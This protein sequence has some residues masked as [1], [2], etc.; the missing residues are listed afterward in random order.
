MTALPHAATDF[1]LRHLADVRK[2]LHPA[3]AAAATITATMTTTSI[4]T[5]TAA[6]TATA[7][8]TAAAAATAD[9]DASAFAGELAS[10]C[11]E[12]EAA[13]GFLDGVLKGELGVADKAP[14]YRVALLC[15]ATL[16]SEDGAAT[17]P[18][19]ASSVVASD[20]SVEFA[21]GLASGER[22]AV[23][24]VK[25]L[26]LLAA[27]FCA[28]SPPP[29]PPEA[30]AEADREAGEPPE[31]GASAAGDEEPLLAEEASVD[32]SVESAKDDTDSIVPDEVDDTFTSALPVV[33]VP[34]P[35]L[36]SS[37][38][39]AASVAA[40]AAA[41]PSTALGRPAKLEKRESM[42]GFMKA[43]S[44]VAGRGACKAEDL[45]DGDVRQLMG[46]IEGIPSLA[47]SNLSRKLREATMSDEERTRVRVDGWLSCVAVG[48]ARV[49]ARATVWRWG[50]SNF[51]WFSGRVASSLPRTVGAVSRCSRVAWFPLFSRRL[52]PPRTL[53]RPPPSIRLG[54]GEAA[55][56]TAARGRGAPSGVRAAVSRA[57]GGRA[58]RRRPGA[59]HTRKPSRTGGHL[60]ERPRGEVKRAITALRAEG[61][62]ACVRVCVRVCVCLSVS[63]SVCAMMR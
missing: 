61:G 58:A 22:R 16:S 20:P 50:K 46:M 30:E 32:L 28:A 41:V 53:A 47:S 49:N 43:A 14:L 10:G 29:P 59:L 34:P 38:Q 42:W 25:L 37:L 56:A 31:E 3:A 60:R 8:A 45:G 52:S 1:V 4:A 5:A 62:R 44:A 57:A 63:V 36:Q 54:S 11:V 40:S 33:S 55:R 12:V 27:L 9:A 15:L 51:D 35:F 48:R 17:S 6:A 7:T 19:A 13:K 39:S 18:Q 2:L 21:S 26:A 24:L 23:P